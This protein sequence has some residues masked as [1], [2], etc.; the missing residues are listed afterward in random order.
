ML[1]IFLSQKGQLEPPC[2]WLLLWRYRLLGRR[3]FG[4]C[5]HWKYNVRFP[6]RAP[7][8]SAACSNCHSRTYH[9]RDLHGAL[10]R[11]G[12]NERKTGRSF[13]IC[14]IQKKSCIRTRLPAWVLWFHRFHA[15]HSHDGS[16]LHLHNSHGHN[17]DTQH[18]RLFKKRYAHL[19]LQNKYTQVL[20]RVNIYSNGTAGTTC[21]NKKGSL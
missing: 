3:V 19:I 4:V 11:N 2:F 7:C 21:D 10:L 8:G 20:S 9:L 15:K 1:Q 14:I 5:C 16:I 6:K 12:K 18:Q 17:S 13:R